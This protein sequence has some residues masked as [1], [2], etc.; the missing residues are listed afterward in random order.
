MTRDEIR[1][2]YESFVQGVSI[3]DLALRCRCSPKKFRNL[4][5]EF[6]GGEDPHEHR[7]ACQQR[8]TEEISMRVSE[9]FGTRPGY[10]WRDSRQREAVYPRYAVWRVAAEQGV[11][12][13][14]IARLFEMNH[15]TVAYG[16]EKAAIL[17]EHSP[18]YAAKLNRL[19]ELA[20]AAA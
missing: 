14:C 4:L 8:R 17:S 9:V 6:L 7:Q 11:P 1:P 19:R 15:T 16:V 2:F 3:A 13:E 20:R 10:V 18:D 5:K 12:L